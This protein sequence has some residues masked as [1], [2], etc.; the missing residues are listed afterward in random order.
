M[1]QKLKNIVSALVVVMLFLPSIVKLEHHHIHFD[2]PLK[3]GMLIHHA[4][5]KCAACD[6]EYS[7]FLSETID[8]IISKAIYIDSYRVDYTPSYY[9]DLSKYSFSLRAP[10][11]FN[12]T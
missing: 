12:K 9:S 3:S 7:V 2:Y 8:I 11:A 1:T 10:P 6:F 5:E 4:Y